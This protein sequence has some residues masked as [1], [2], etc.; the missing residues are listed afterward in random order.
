[1]KTKFS[2]Q[3][4]LKALKETIKQ[5]E[6]QQL[7]TLLGLAAVL[8]HKKVLTQEDVKLVLATGEE[9]LTKKWE[10]DLED[11]EQVKQL[12]SIL[13]MQRMFGGEK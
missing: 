9:I 5:P 13:F 6:N 11:P 8:V 10:K 1:M 4:R 3:D 2:T 12:D 7:A